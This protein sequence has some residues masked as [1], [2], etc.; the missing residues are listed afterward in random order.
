MHKTAFW[1]LVI[2]GFLVINTF[3]TLV[4][5]WIGVEHFGN[6]TSTTGLNDFLQLFYFS[7]QTLTTVGYGHFTQKVI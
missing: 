6:L 7:A 1:G 4:Y 3:F 5:M 2:L